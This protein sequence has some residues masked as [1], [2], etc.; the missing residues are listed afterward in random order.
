MLYK[1]VGIGLLALFAIIAIPVT[2]NAET[3]D[4][5]MYGMTTL[6]LKDS[7]GNVL[8]ETI[9]HNEVLDSG[10]RYMLDKM[11]FQ[12]SP[13]NTSNRLVNAICVTNAPNF[14]VVEGHSP[15]NFNSPDTL[16][17]SRCIANFDYTITS[18]SADSL[19]QTFT[20]ATHIDAGSVITGIGVCQVPFNVSPN[21]AFDCTTG[22]NSVMFAEIDITD[23]IVNTNNDLEVRYV[24]NLD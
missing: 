3:D 21:T 10:T 2:T 19:T 8:F 1:Y 22:G 24:L 23:T 18:N 17:K 4:P 15:S 14:A 20:T 9:L 6:A 13:L 11:F 12:A 16:T 7:T 5:R